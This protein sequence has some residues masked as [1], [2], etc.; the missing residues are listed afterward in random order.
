MIWGRI[1]VHCFT[2]GC[3]IIPTPFIGKVSLSSTELSCHPCENQMTRS[4]TSSL[5]AL[6]TCF[7][8]KLVKIVKQN[9]TQ[10][11]KAPGY[12]PKD[13]QQKKK[14][15]LKKIYENSVKHVRACGIWTKTTLSSSLPAEWGR[16]C[17]RLLRAEH[18]APSASSSQSERAFCP[19][20]TELCCSCPATSY[21]WLRLRP[22][23]TWSRGVRSPYLPSHVLETQPLPWERHTES[24]GALMILTPAHGMV[25]LYQKRLLY[26]PSAKHS[27]F[28]LRVSLKEEL[29]IVSTSS[30][31]ALAQRFWL[32]EDASHKP[33]SSQYLPPKT[34]FICNRAC[35]S[36]S[37]R[38]PSRSVEIVVKGNWERSQD[39]V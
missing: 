18:R 22:Q 38:T 26:S 7:L 27:A 17:T 37:L 10:P 36:W 33:D 5:T 2:C 9:K 11:F 16:D 31:K 32:E 15:V 35:R 13:K 6:L 29:A 39:I 20:G 12:G 19:V 14:Q 1:Q 21:L 34:D 4:V 8:V 30:S 3:P 25:V 24:A 28:M 23:Q